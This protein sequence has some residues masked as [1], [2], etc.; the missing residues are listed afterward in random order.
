MT[1]LQGYEYFTDDTGATKAMQISSGEV[2]ETVWMCLPIGSQ[3]RTPEGIAAQTEYLKLKEL[4]EL[5]RLS[6]KDLGKFFFVSSEEDFKDLLPQTVTRLIYLNTFTHFGDNKLMLTERTPM[7]RKNLAEILGV[8]KAVITKFWK[9]VSPKYIQEQDGGLIFT[10]TDIFIKRKLNQ[11]GNYSPYQKFYISGIRTLYRATS[12]SNHKHLGY[13]FKMLPFINL[14]YNV[15]CKNPLEKDLEKIQLLSLAEFCNAIGY[16]I[17]QLTRLLNIYQNISF[18][19]KGKQENFC[20]F[21]YSGFD[22]KTSRI[23]VNPHI[24]YNG[25]NYNKVKVLGAFCRD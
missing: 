13:I 18:D 22:R 9:E 23:F 10:N 14:E 1:E 12:V 7:K 25:T 20:A 16:N 21:A 8:S 4:N 17:S 11:R 19:V 6:N 5:R 2:T 24:L 3:I 15:L